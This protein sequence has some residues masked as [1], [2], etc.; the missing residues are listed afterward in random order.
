MSIAFNFTLVL[1][2]SL[3]NSF[4]IDFS[5][6]MFCVFFD[7]I[8]SRH[9]SQRFAAR[10]IGDL[11]PIECPRPKTM[12]PTGP[13]TDSPRTVTAMSAVRQ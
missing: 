9:Q 6:C 12:A 10:S 11:V 1:L 7:E 3:Y 13:Q 4:T 8:D 5:A 2:V